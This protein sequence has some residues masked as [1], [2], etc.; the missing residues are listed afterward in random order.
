MLV[1]V[2]SDRAADVV[3]LKISKL[4]GLTRTKQVR[5]LCISMGIAMTLEDSWGGDITTAAI[6]S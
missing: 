5:D 1:R 4:G 6:A 3:N 2:V